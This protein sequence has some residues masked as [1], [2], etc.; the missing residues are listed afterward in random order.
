MDRYLRATHKNVFVATV[1][2]SPGTDAVFKE[3]QSAGRS[4]VHFVPIMIVAGDHILNDVMGD[5][6]DSWK[7]RL[8]MEASIEKGL[9]E[10]PDVVDLF[11]TR[12]KTALSSFVK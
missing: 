7:S 8:G 12:L 3:I 4:K 10:N 6:P 1:E 5:E 9:G 2:G 11:I